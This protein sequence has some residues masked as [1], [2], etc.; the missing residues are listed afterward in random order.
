MSFTN[1]VHLIHPTRQIVMRS[2]SISFKERA[3]DHNRDLVITK[4][5]VGLHI[6]YCF[7]NSCKFCTE[8]LSRNE[9]DVQ[10]QLTYWK[11]YCDEIGINFD[12]NHTF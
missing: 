9:E 3:E 1:F 7:D 2:F 12:P 5:D 6:T 8:N 10:T 4:A 11:Q